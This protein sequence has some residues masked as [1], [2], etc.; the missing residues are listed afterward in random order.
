MVTP[1]G[2]PEL[3]AVPDPYGT[4]TIRLTVHRGNGQ[5][6]KKHRGKTH[7]FGPL[8]D[9]QLAIAN[10]LSRWPRIVEGLPDR[11]VH[12]ET[13]AQVFEAF[14][15]DSDARVESGE[16]GWAQH[17]AYL[18]T[19]KKIAAEIGGR[20]RIG[21][22]TPDAW[23]RAIAS[24]YAGSSPITKH[25]SVVRLRTVLKWA[26]RNLGVQTTTGDALRP[27]PARLRRRHKRL[28]GDRM[29]TPGQIRKLI[30]TCRRPA[31]GK[32][33]ADA[34]VTEACLWLAINGGMR[35]ADI[36]HLTPSAYRRAD[37]VTGGVRGWIDEPRHKT[38]SPR[39]FP[40]W[41][42]TADA[43]D[44]AIA[45][46]AWGAD[47]AR[48]TLL[49][50]TAGTPLLKPRDDR[51]QKRFTALRN[52]AWPK[53]SH[54]R[55]CSFQWFRYTH[56]TVASTAPIARPDLARLVR[57]LIVGHI[58]DHNVH[59]AYLQTLPDAPF[60]ETVLHVRRWLLG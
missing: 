17:T 45:G 34:L 7:Y 53:G 50:T 31:A 22:I 19:L 56:I 36:G 6:C 3:P 12:V 46:H 44:A 26:E 38:E 32:G 51:I 8:D 24:V 37:Q 47:P 28:A 40:L 11:T 14:L 35:Q 41:P 55:D 5:W 58:T 4:G 42:E 60:L 39:R 20:T 16:R 13:L 54:Y 2:T 10:Y 52:R 23:G 57:L 29:L 59:D 48:A 49:C 9:P 43:L 25:N 33:R 18:G 21:L 15:T 30:K 1:E 27:V